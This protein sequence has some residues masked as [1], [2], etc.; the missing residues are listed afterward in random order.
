MGLIKNGGSPRKHLD[1]VMQLKFF[2]DQW[3]LCQKLVRKAYEELCRNHNGDFETYRLLCYTGVM[4]FAK[5][6]TR[7]R[8]IALFAFEKMKETKSKSKHQRVVL[9]YWLMLKRS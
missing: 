9:E 6:P 4:F 7:D 8:A 3:E 2:P 5:S 1:V